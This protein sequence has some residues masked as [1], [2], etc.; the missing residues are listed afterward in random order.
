MITIGSI[1]LALTLSQAGV[2]PWKELDP[3]ARG[4]AL[5]AAFAQ[6]LTKRLLSNSERFLGVPYLASPLGEGEGFDADPTL[7]FD[8]VD[9][10][11]FVEET[12]ALSLSQ[13]WE[14]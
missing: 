2:T 12:I 8:A 13:R 10:L 11:T 5:T 3:A 4:Q 9:C 14:D 7:R 6:P 1:A